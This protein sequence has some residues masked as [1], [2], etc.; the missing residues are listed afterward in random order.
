MLRCPHAP[1]L[2]DVLL[3]LLLPC[4]LEVRNTGQRGQLGAVMHWSALGAHQ[5][6]LQALL[7]RAGPR[8]AL[9]WMVLLLLLL[10][11][12]AVPPALLNLVRNQMHHLHLHPSQLLL[13]ACQICWLLLWAAPRKNHWLLQAAACRNRWLP[14]P[15]LLPLLLQQGFWLCQ[16]TA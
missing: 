3:L 16:G 13:D 8:Q 12:Q 7:V 1:L 14:L 11:T 9:L 10:A 2:T 6:C 4:R 5:W 15:L